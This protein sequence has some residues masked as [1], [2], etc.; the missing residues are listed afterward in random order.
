M[1]FLILETGL[2]SDISKFLFACLYILFF[3]SW[4]RIG[5]ACDYLRISV[6]FYAVRHYFGKGIAG[7]YPTLR[8]L[9]NFQNGKT[10]ENCREQKYASLLMPCL[11]FLLLFLQGVVV[12]VACIR[13][14]VIITPLLLCS[15][16]CKR[17]F[18]K[19]RLKPPFS[20]E[21]I[22]LIELMLYL[23]AKASLSLN[24]R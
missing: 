11:Y 6:A 18:S 8:Y 20:S 16:F 22:S 4:K 12:F 10:R 9:R 14:I 5:R 17:T 3:S 2:R 13:R 1:W 21:M 15:R 19:G 24:R 23:L 7:E